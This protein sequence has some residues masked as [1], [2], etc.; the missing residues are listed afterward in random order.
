V[1][2]SVTIARSGTLVRREQRQVAPRLVGRAALVEAAVREETIHLGAAGVDPVRHPAAP[3]HRQDVVVAGDH[4]VER[5]GARPLLGAE[6]VDEG[7]ARR[8]RRAG[9]RGLDRGPV[10]VADVVEERKE[11]VEDELAVRVTLHVAREEDGQRLEDAAAQHGERVDRAGLREEPLA[12]AERV[13]V[14]GAR[15]AD[16]ATADVRDQDV[17]ADVL[18]DGREIDLGA[19]VDG[20]ALQ[21]DLPGLVEAD[22]PAERRPGFHADAQ[23]TPLHFDRAYPHIRPVRDEREQTGH[24]TTPVLRLAAHSPSSL[25][26]CAAGGGRAAAG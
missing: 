22:A 24:A 25:S 19:V 1:R 8:Q 9:A 16:G 11:Q 23:V 15:R 20:T 2:V 4:E 18:R 5:A 12:E 3:V 14:L 21:Q 6:A 10:E 17:G 26:S 13:R 7:Q